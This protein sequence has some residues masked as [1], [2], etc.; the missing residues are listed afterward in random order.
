MK[1]LL[2]F[3]LFKKA[4]VYDTL[5]LLEYLIDNSEITINDS[6]LNQLNRLNYYCRRSFNKYGTNDAY[7]LDVINILQY[8]S[9]D[10]T[11]VT[12]VRLKNFF[13]FLLY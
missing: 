8:I 13:F 1:D 6:I 12:K 2:I 9:N 4:D 10:N 11:C 5:K 3:L 7:N